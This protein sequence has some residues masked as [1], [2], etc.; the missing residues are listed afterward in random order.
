MSIVTKWKDLK[1]EK[2]MVAYVLFWICAIGIG[3]GAIM[4]VYPN[5]LTR[6]ARMGSFAAPYALY[7]TTCVGTGLILLAYSAIWFIDDKKGSTKVRLLLMQSLKR[8]NK[9][10]D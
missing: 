8:L 9:G 2:P 4:V 3:A 10:G 5:A 7:M 6:T 1:A